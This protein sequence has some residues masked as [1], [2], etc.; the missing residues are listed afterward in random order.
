MAANDLTAARL[1]ELLNYDQATGVFVWR[2]AMRYGVGAGGP[3]GSMCSNGYLKIKVGGKRLSAH[4]IAWLFVTGEWPSDM[5]DH[6]NGVRS[7]NRFS[8]LRDASRAVNQQNQRHAQKSN[9]ST[10]VLGVSAYESGGVRRYRVRVRGFGKT[11]SESFMTLADAA[12]RAI[13]L[14]RE[15][16]PGNT[17]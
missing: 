13:E 10:G 3:A 14:R 4:R 17:L 2:V 1:R 9:T 6:I 12:K 15:M 11:R 5:I 16:Q 8:N 7:D